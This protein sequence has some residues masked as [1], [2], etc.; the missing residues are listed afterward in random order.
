MLQHTKS[1][2]LKLKLALKKIE[3]TVD[4]STL[5]CSKNGKLVRC[6]VPRTS[7][8]RLDDLSRIIFLC[9]NLYF[10]NSCSRNGSSN[11]TQYLNLTSL[12]V[13]R[14]R[15]DFKKLRCPPQRSFSGSGTNS[16]LSSISDFIKFPHSYKVEGQ[17]RGREGELASFLIILQSSSYLHS[18]HFIKFYYYLLL[19]LFCLSCHFLFYPIM[20]TLLFSRKSVENNLTDLHISY[21]SQTP[22]VRLHLVC[23]FSAIHIGSN[24]FGNSALL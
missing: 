2:A 18:I 19:Q 6:L 9:L 10:Y 14:I 4:K 12:E 11:S 16:T 5:F 1:L 22:L 3:L 24:L 13:K 23:C 8:G 15:I 17:P 21:A 7:W 20:I